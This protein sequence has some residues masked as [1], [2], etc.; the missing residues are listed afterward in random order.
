[1]KTVTSWPSRASSFGSDP[2]TS[3]SPPVFAIGE[4]S[5][6]ANTILIRA[7]LHDQR[8]VTDYALVVTAHISGGCVLDE[9]G[10]ACSQCVRCDEHRR[11]RDVPAHRYVILLHHLPE[12][13][14]LAG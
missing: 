2:Q 12:G 3:P 9:P 11:G 7:L 14:G 10:L 4:T 1:M 8:R 13:L 6:V 5:A